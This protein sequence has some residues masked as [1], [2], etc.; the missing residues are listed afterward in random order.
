MRIRRLPRAIRDVDDIWLHIAA[1][2]PAAATRLVERLATGVARLSDFPESG[3]AR[4]EIGTGARS[5]VVG[6]Y[7]VLYRVNGEC[8]DIV[9]VIHGARE[10]AGL[11]DGADRLQ[12]GAP[13]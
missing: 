13:R 1:D 10:I 6:G 11:L 2:D 3:P 12:G 4:P 8:V 9:R 5:L 7:L